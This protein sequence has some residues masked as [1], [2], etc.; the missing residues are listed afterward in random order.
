MPPDGDNNKE[1]RELIVKQHPTFYR[2]MSIV[3]L[4]G[5]LFNL[6]ICANIFYGKN[7]LSGDV[8]IFLMGISIIL[9]L[10]FGFYMSTHVSCP[11]CSERCSLYSDDSGKG[12]Q[13]LCKNCGVIWDLGVSYNQDSD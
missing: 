8:G 13:V 7:I 1:K 9:I 10:F 5:F 3:I 11:Y 2:Y 6:L 12:R 4:S